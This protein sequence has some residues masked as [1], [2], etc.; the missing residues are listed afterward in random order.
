MAQSGNSGN[1][2]SPPFATKDG[3]PT[4]QGTT[5]GGNDFLTNPTGT[6]DK[7]GG[8]DFLADGNR[9]QPAFKEPAN[10]DSIPAG[11]KILKADPGPV[12]KKVSGTA[13]AIANKTPFK[14]SK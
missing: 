12:S 9:K 8:K 10:P 7:S 11:G 2:A 1:G 13:T 4:N 14:L 6:G 3:K 5:G